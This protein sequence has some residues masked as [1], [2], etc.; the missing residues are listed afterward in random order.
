[1][2]GNSPI[3]E[4]LE[5]RDITDEVENESGHD[6]SKD[7]MLVGVQDRMI[8]KIVKS[9][10]LG[11]GETVKD[12]TLSPTTES[13]GVILKDLFNEK[14]TQKDRQSVVELICDILNSDS[15]DTLMKISSKVI[16]AMNGMH[17]G[18]REKGTKDG[19]CAHNTLLGRYFSVKVERA[20]GKST[21]ERTIERGAMIE[22]EECKGRLFLVTAVWKKVGVK[23][24][25]SKQ[26][27][28]PVW[29]KG[30]DDKNFRIGV[31]EVSRT[32]DEGIANY[33]SINISKKDGGV[34]HGENHRDCYRMT[35][36]KAIVEFYGKVDI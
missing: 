5:E 18:K 35:S 28:L 24:F 6:I 11:A 30:V 31:R 26:K 13:D 3:N 33:L 4:N 22:I 20:T 17:M 36:L 19:A 32:K 2:N 12:V 16:T 23:W 29:K 1:M 14:I 10:S 15:R 25:L 21:G 34:V 9:N 7:D 8:R 27:D